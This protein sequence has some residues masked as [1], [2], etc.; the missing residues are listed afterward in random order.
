MVCRSL[1]SQYQFF[2]T[3]FRNNDLVC[4]L[5]AT[6]HFL[7]LFILPEYQYQT[8]LF[9]NLLFSIKYILCLGFEDVLKSYLVCYRVNA[10]IRLIAVVRIHNYKLKK[11]ICNCQILIV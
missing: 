6:L 5:L 10:N 3:V 7:S 9:Y 2:I 11:K 1:T 8:S 4:Y